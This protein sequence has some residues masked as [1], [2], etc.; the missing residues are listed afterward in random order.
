M[1]GRYKNVVA[2]AK[3]KTKKK[4]LTNVKLHIVDSMSTNAGAPT[5]GI[6]VQEYMREHNEAPELTLLIHSTGMVY[7]AKSYSDQADHCEWTYLNDLGHN[8]PEKIDM[9]LACEA[10]IRQY[11]DEK[12]APNWPSVANACHTRLNTAL[13]QLRLWGQDVGPT[14]AYSTSSEDD[15]D[16]DRAVVDS[17]EYDESEEE[18]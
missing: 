10:A 9:A 18:F 3:R 12:I 15:Y 4:V 17:E 13:E 2:R 14:P 8:H 11:I 1:T 6:A 5:S 7:Y 16:E